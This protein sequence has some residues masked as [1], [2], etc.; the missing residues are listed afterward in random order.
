MADRVVAARYAEALFGV[1]DDVVR[2][3]AVCA[4][5]QAIAALVD[6]NTQL[7]AFLEGPNIVEQH[8]LDLVRRTF[9]GKVEHETL[10]FLQ[11]LLDRHRIDHLADATEAFTRLVEERRNQVRVQVTTAIPLPADM[12]ERLKRALDAAIDKDCLLE[13]RVDQRVIGGV[14]AVI[15][16]RVFDGSLRHHIGELRKQ[17][18]AAPLR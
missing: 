5:L 1:I 13:T 12:H 18:K 11:L 17:L 8:K 15:G 2:L 4:E 16:D 7:K 6:E 3:D 10:D 14:I 9:E